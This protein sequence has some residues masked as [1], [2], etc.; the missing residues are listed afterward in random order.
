MKAVLCICKSQKMF[1]L[2]Q[3]IKTRTE[4]E[5]SRVKT[6]ELQNENQ[7]LR[8]QVAEAEKVLIFPVH[9]EEHL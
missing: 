7:H 5:D 9:A 1:V 6:E 8:K 3:V 2:M 4:A